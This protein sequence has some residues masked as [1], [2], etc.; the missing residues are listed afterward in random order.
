MEYRGIAF[1]VVV[2]EPTPSKNYYL[3]NI[4]NNNNNNM[5]SSADEKLAI[6]PA[7][8][9]LAYNGLDTEASR[10]V[11]IRFPLLIWGHRRPSNI[12][13]PLLHI[14]SQYINFETTA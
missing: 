4:N 3:H 8:A 7:G 6:L 10:Y 14:I 5:L 13:Y 9:R 2:Q 11:N 1:A 12:M